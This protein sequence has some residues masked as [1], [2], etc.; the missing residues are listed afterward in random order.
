MLLLVLG[1]SL[2][3]DVLCKL[4]EVSLLFGANLLPFLVALASAWVVVVGPSL[5]SILIVITGSL[6]RSL[7]CL[8]IYW[9]RDR[10]FL[11]VLILSNSGWLK[12][13]GEGVVIV[14]WFWCPGGNLGIAPLGAGR[15]CSTVLMGG[16]TFFLLWTLSMPLGVR[17]GVGVSVRGVWY[18]E[19]C[20]SPLGE[21]VISVMLSDITIGWSAGGIDAGATLLVVRMGR[22]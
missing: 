12:S 8:F 10:V 7:C 11:G 13:M 3:K 21:C 15:V 17:A 4:W 14:V 1:I 6:L 5:P 9:A 18:T 16:C 2:R 22:P 20:R 19:V